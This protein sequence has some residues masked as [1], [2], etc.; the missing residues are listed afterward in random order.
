L[1]AAVS[2]AD[3]AAAGTAQVTVLSPAPGGGTS[4]AQTFTINAANNTSQNIAPL[5][6]VTASSEA[7]QYGQLAIKAVDGVVDGYPGDYTREWSTVGEKAGAWLNLSWSS[8]Y[9]VDHVVL[10]DRPNTND[11]ILL[12]TL[13]FSDG[14]TIQVGPLVNGG[15]GLTATFTPKSTTSLRMRVDQVSSTTQNIGL[16][17]IQVFGY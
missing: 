9:M 7:A 10:Y 12:A 17:E 6:V 1:T 4:N 11:Q 3:I 8:P 15:A 2:A 5:A 16:S 13:I 14:S